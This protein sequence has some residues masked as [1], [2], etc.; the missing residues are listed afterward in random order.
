MDLTLTTS[1]I[2]IISGIL[3]GFINTLA[4]GG[5]IISISLFMFLGLPPIVANGTNRIPILFQTITAVILYQKKK[6]IEWSKAIKLSIPIIAGNITGALL[7]GLLPDKIFSYIF[8]GIVVLF[9]ISMLFNPNTWLKENKALQIKPITFLQYVTYFFLG[10]Y[11]GFVH[12]GIGYFYL[13]MLVLVGGYDIIKANVLKIVF[14]MCSI[15][16]SL[17]V[18]AVQGNVVWSAGLIHAIGNVIG[19]SIGVNFAVKKGGNF[20]RYIMLTLIVL[21]ALQL[22]GIL[23]AEKILSF[24]K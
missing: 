5:T 2:L 23:T 12:V 21:V 6:M 3:V 13:G 17:M 22:M 20:V 14:V 24:L 7:A 4:G 19:A 8:A 16:F 11:G 18:F 15:P 10:V 1:I 9:G